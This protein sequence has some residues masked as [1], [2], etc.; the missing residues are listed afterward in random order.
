MSL[1]NM[2]AKVAIGYA[3]AKGVQQVSRS[4]GLGKVMEGMKEQA[5]QAGAGGGGLPGGLGD[6]M[7]QIGGGASGGQPGGLGGLGGL[8]GGLAEA[9]SGNAGQGTSLEDLLSQDNPPEEPE[10]DAAGGLMIRAMIMAARA[11]GE[12]DDTEKAKLLDTIGQ[13]S[14]QEEMA[15][16]QQA[17]QEPVS[18][19]TLAA[20]TPK[21]LE[22][23]VYAMSVMAVEPDNRQEAQYL[24]NLASALGIGAATANDIHDKFG[25]PRLYS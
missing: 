21:G 2:A 13:G 12:I 25:V 15:F 16:V 8:L 4:G 17:M 1:L 10:E 18:A 23:Q 24:H 5:A 14:S 7:S 9:K 19:E 11:D 6:I 20:D 22:T 3:L